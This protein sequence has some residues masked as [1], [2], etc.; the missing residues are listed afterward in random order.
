MTANLRRW[1]AELIGTYGFVVIGA[2]SG[3][4]IGAKLG[5]AGLL[6]VAIA[7][8]VG[9]G[10][11]ITAF[12]A[13]SGGHLNPAVTLSAWIGRKIEAADA[14]GY[15]AAQ[16]LGALGAGLTLRTIFP[17]SV[18]RST[19]LG[20]P[21][22]AQGVSVGRAVLIEAVFTFFLLIVIWG[23]AIDDRAPSVGGL[24]IGLT[25]VVGVLA[26][27]PLTGGAFNPARYLGPAAVAGHLTDWWV[28]FAGPAIGGAVAGVIYPTIFM[29]G[30]P[31]TPAPASAP[32]A[33]PAAS[34]EETG[35]P[36]PAPKAPARKPAARRKAAPRRATR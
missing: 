3:I 34:S 7:N 16:L 31:W 28:Y 22:I 20:A 17:D 14:I 35:E 19:V 8:G 11:M 32:E 1:I 12:M 2:G 23:T 26:I 15:V 13:I 33:P 25:V 24:F 4:L 9:L 5:D 18:W 21:Q 36:R 6:G 29:G 27:G 30:F 10:V